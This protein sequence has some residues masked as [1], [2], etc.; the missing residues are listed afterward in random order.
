MEAMSS[1]WA[2]RGRVV[3]PTEIVE[4]GVVVLAGEEIAFVGSLTEAHD[5]G[6]DKIVASAS[7]PAAGQIVTP[8]LI[9]IHCHGGGGTSFPDVTDYDQVLVGIETHRRA[10]TT[11][12]VASLVTADPETLRTRTALLTKAALAG[13]L[14]GIHLEG[15]F[16]SAARC[17]AQDPTKMQAPSPA[18]VRE[19]AEIA[20]GHFFTMTVAAEL[21]GM[22]GEGG[23]AQTLI[24]CGAL[25]SYGHSDAAE[26]ETRAGLSESFAQLS[27]ALASEET[28]SSVRSGRPTVTHLFNGMRPVHHREAG[29]IPDALAAAARGEAV[30][31]LVADGTHLHPALVREVFELVGADNIVF[32]TDAMA[33]AGMPDGRYRLGSLDVEVTDRVARLVEGGSIAGGT[34]RLS[35]VVRVSVAGGV[36]LHDAITSATATPAMVLGR[37]DIGALAAGKR[38]DVVVFDADMVVQGVVRGGKWVNC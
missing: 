24:E 14:A 3:T 9:D 35:D 30:V 16:L 27:A 20:Q 34:A 22:L 15:P 8:G 29:P 33:A 1:M 13:E 5:A 10:G 23:V 31:E 21:P 11:T 4:D 36:P 28:A 38:S 17:G 18:L 25:P 32:I 12:M 7:S 6:Y 19:I 26:G 37:T 2:I